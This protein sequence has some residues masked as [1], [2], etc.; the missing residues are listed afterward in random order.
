MVHR[1]QK[2]VEIV[3]GRIGYALTS[4]ALSEASDG[5]TWEPDASF[6][7]ADAILDDPEFV[8]VLRVVLRDGHIIVPALKAKGM[9]GN[10][11]S[12]DPG[13]SLAERKA[14][15][16]REAQEAMSDHEDAQR[17]LHGNRE[18]LRAERMAREAAA[19][20]M[21]YPSPELPDDTPIENVRFSTR[22]RNALDAAGM[23]TIGEVRETS[24]DNLLS[25]QDL[26]PSSIS[27]L[28]ESLGLPS[29]D[30]V[31]PTGKKPA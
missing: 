31:R 17:A 7:V 4:A 13:L 29:T 15:R 5:A 11:K 24:D 8:S 10:E 1:V 20:P 3:S 16:A 26:G 23:K 21:L 2:F 12:T 19:G 30:G 27:Y 9:T 6:N 22:I 18:R 14:L 28:R 25:L